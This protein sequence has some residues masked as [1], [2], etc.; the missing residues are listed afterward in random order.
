MDPKRSCVCGDNTRFGVLVVGTLCFSLYMATGIAFYTAL[1][2]MTDL[3]S[4]PLF[5]ND[6]SA[7]VDYGSWDLPTADRRFVYT[8]MEKSWLIGGLFLGVLIGSVPMIAFMTRFGPHLTVILIGSAS[9]VLTALVPLAASCGFPFLVAVRFVQGM[10]VANIFPLIGAIMMRWA[11]LTESG[12]FISLYTAYIQLSIIIST[13]ISGFVGK[14]LNWPSIFYIH[15][16]IA[17]TLTVVWALFFRNNPAKHPF[18][19]EQE[20]RK[21]STGKPPMQSIKRPTNIP[22]KAILTSLP[23]WAVWIACVGNYLATQFSIAFFYMYL[24]WVLGIDVETAGLLTPIS[25]IIQ[26]ALNAT[27]QARPFPLLNPLQCRFFNSLAF[28]G[29]AFFFVVVAFV[30]PEDKLICALLAMV[31]QAMIGFNPGGFN[32]SSVLV[33]RQHSPTVLAVT[34]V[35]LCVTLFS[36]SF[37]VLALTPNNTFEEYRSVFLLYAAGL[38]VTNTIFVIFCRAEAAEWTK[39]KKVYPET[40]STA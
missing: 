12:L 31:P 29:A 15:A 2:P 16:A 11:A 26:L 4:S 9:T 27:R 38:A 1:V 37:I 5:S 6:S 17:G 18:V 34:Q 21:I 14:N 8:V 24:V 25:L 40:I 20:I 36:G 32:K 13:P 35:I 7:E 3:S 19:G 30:H 23:I 33:A 28:Y 10:G 22:Y 39:D